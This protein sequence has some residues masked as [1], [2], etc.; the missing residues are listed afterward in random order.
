MVSHSRPKLPSITGF[1]PTV[2]QKGQ[3]LTH[4]KSI[5]IRMSTFYLTAFKKILLDHQMTLELDYHTRL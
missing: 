4:L 3:K 5:D 2:I 1:Y